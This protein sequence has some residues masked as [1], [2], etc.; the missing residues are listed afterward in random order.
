TTFMGIEMCVLICVL[1]CVCKCVCVWVCVSHYPRPYVSI[2]N[3]FCLH[4]WLMVSNMAPV[5]CKVSSGGNQCIYTGV[6]K[7]HC[8]KRATLRH[9]SHTRTHAHT[10]T[11]THTGC[12][13]R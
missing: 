11:H 13:S 10:H 5:M 12:G 4:L 3:R 8:L 6:K 7:K 9:L 1:M 2:C